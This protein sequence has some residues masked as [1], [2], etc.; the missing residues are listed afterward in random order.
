MPLAAQALG[1]D[2]DDDGCTTTRPWTAT[3]D[4]T[5]VR[6]GSSIGSI[7]TRVISKQDLYIF[8]QVIGKVS[9]RVEIRMLSRVSE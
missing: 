2:D 5:S 7:V 9:S 6:S 3:N 8:L 1:C 4:G